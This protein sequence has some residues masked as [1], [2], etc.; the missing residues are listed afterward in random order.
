LLV[1]AALRRIEASLPLF[2][3]AALAFAVL[4]LPIWSFKAVVSG[5]S[6]CERRW[7]G[8][9]WCVALR[10]VV[11]TCAR[12][13]QCTRCNGSCEI[14]GGAN[15]AASA[16]AGLSHNPRARRACSRSRDLVAANRFP[17]VRAAPLLAA[18]LF[19]KDEVLRLLV[20]PSR[21][22]S[23]ADLAR[24]LIFKRV[25]AVKFSHEEALHHCYARQFSEIERKDALEHGRR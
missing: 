23:K 17:S 6:R 19:R 20:G 15:C 21:V 24:L 25:D 14:S 12:S 2:S 13:K 22:E 9:H 1:A 18:A 10:M 4:L 16:A 8:C 3:L 5:Y 7:R 11:Q